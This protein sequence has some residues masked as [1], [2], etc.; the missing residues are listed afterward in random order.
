MLSSNLEY[1]VVIV[2]AGPAGVACAIMLAQTHLKVA[3]LDK[4]TFPRDKICGDAL[5]LDVINQLSMLSPAL[6]AKFDQFAQKV[7]SYG[8]KI[9][10]PAG[11]DIDIPF[12]NKC[13][14]DCGYVCTRTDFDNLLV[15]HLKELQ[16][17]ELIE[18]CEVKGIERNDNGILIQTNKGEIKS[19][20]VVGADGAHSVVNRHLGNIEVDKNHYSAGLRMYFDGVSGF[21]DQGYIELYFFKNILPGYLWVFPLP[22]GK[23]NVGIGMLSSA[24]MSKKVNLK[25]AFRILLDEHPKLKARFEHATALE[26]VKGFGL[27]L[28][29]KKRKLSG[30]HFLLTGDA[31]SLIDP[32]TGEGIGNAIRSGRVAAMHIEKSFEQQDFSA[33]FNQA[34]DREI[35]DRMWKELKLSRSLQKLCK[36]PWLFNFIVKKSNQSRQVHEYL[37]ES[38]ANINKKKYLVRPD[39]LFK[40]L[41]RKN[42]MN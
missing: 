37:I 16:Q 41:T 21:H 6:A 2:G 39:F 18:A 19:R 31:A 7:P 29:S 1:D 22:D 17:V 4:S 30:D 28:G 5:S 13:K 32:F 23:A 10:A 20:F 25:K 35:Y 38:L 42:G 9:I 27:P 12:I 11:N 33:R 24:V 34:Y 36:Y 14:K 40:L 15:E 8:V 26:T 3:I